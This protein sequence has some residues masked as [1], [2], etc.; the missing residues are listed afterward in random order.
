MKI[1]TATRM[2]AFL[3][4]GL[5]ALTSCSSGDSAT[6]MQWFREAARR[7]DA[8]PEVVEAVRRMEP[9]LGP[10][11]AA[12]PAAPQKAKRRSRAPASRA[13]EPADPGR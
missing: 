10:A 3:T 11:G 9:A 4:V 12:A 7:P 1:D 6:A 13:H 2:G 8:P 5:L